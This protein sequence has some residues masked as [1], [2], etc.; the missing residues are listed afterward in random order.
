MED[1]AIGCL[2]HS[3]K[4]VLNQGFVNMTELMN[5]WPRKKRN[6][7]TLYLILSWGFKTQ[8][9]FSV[10]KSTSREN[11]ADQNGDTRVEQKINANLSQHGKKVSQLSLLSHLLFP[12]CST[13]IQISHVLMWN[14]R[15]C[16]SS[17][18]DSTGGA[19]LSVCWTIELYPF[20]FSSKF[21]PLA[22]DQTYRESYRIW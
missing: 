3:M 21:L 9:N 11:H 10:L 12:L 18:E 16:S 7:N 5:E 22:L 19:C 14:R 15:N 2:I 17:T 8:L 6:V 13:S 1:S 4:Y 20:L